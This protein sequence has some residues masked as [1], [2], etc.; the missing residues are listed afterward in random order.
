MDSFSSMMTNKSTIR[1]VSRLAV[2]AVFM[3]CGQTTRAQNAGPPSAVQT[4]P[5]AISGEAGAT[6]AP[7]S[8]PAGSI[9]EV[10]R[11]LHEKYPAST[12]VRFT[13]DARTSQILAFGPAAVQDQVSALIQ[14]SG[15][16]VSPNPAAGQTP[17][18]AS[19]PAVDNKAVMR[20]PKVVPLRNL[21]WR[22]FETQLS[23]IFGK[24][25]PVTIEH[26]G[27]WARYTLE[28]RAGRVN[29]IVDR[30]ASQVALE[31]PVRLADA[32]AKVVESLDAHPQQAND[33]TRVVPLGAA[34]SAD[35]VKALSVFRNA[36]ATTGNTIRDSNSAPAGQN[37]N[38][39]RMINMIFQPR[40]GGAA[41]PTDALAQ[42]RVPSLKCRAT[43]RTKTSNPANLASPAPDR[44]R[45]MSQKAAAN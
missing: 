5:A 22:E 45:R 40:E 42:R 13:H 27:D 15:G 26:G 30:K 19:G 18:A 11:K 37:N 7:Y 38:S 31:G 41:N 43:I 3:A 25:L 44:R 14:A 36:A 28:T 24:T 8:V 33:D 1:C 17:A 23:A 21:T 9:D 35:V 20:G 10:L 29:L 16:M 39:G 6:I 2:L 12:G 32:W 4:P 34:K